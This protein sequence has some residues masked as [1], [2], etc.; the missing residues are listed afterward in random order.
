VSYPDP[1]SNRSVDAVLEDKNNLQKM[2]QFHVLKC[3]MFSL[4]IWKLLQLLG[5]LYGG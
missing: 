5:S 3:W 2:K 4:G 1:D